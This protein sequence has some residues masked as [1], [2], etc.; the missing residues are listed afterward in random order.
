MFRSMLYSLVM[1]GVCVGFAAA[2]TAK[3]DTK[4]KT[5]KKAK[6]AKITKVDAKKG[7]VTVKMKHKDKEVEKTF[8][9]AEEIEYMDSTGKVATI[10]IFTSGDEVL[11]VEV[12][13]KI[14]KMKKKEKSATTKKPEGK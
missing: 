12:D 8:K 4:D 6:E 5:D 14:T 3:T 10:E 7:A 9:L 1:L 11:I 13:G 2:D